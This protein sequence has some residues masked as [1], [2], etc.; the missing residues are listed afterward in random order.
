LNLSF[1]PAIAT[2]VRLVLPGVVLLA[3][4]AGGGSQAPLTQQLSSFA[5]QASAGAP[6]RSWISPD[7]TKARLL[8]ASEDEGEGDGFVNIY[9]QNG[10][11]QASIGHLG[12]LDFPIGL[13][14]D[15][16]GNLYVANSNGFNVPVYHRGASMPFKT[17]LDPNEYPDAVTIDS[18]GTVYVAS[19]TTTQHMPGNVA[20]YAGG[21]TSPTSTLTDPNWLSAGAVT[22]DSSNNLYVCFISSSGP[23]GVDEFL[24]GTTMPINLGLKLEHTC[25]GL[26][27]DQHQNLVVADPGALKVEVFPP[28]S[29]SPSITFPAGSGFPG[30]L[31]FANV[32][33]LYASGDN[34]V[35]QVEEFAYPSGKVIN[36]ITNGFQPDFCV[37][38]V[39]TDP[40]VV[41]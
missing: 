17:L 25:N 24:A 16:K 10:K 40:L 4:C 3:G 18:K 8:Y 41:K 13:A 30:N 29:T 26:A 2:V 15:K 38:G 23:Y 34:G 36:K 22:V 31:A 39:A 33:Q 9:D 11:N 27:K 28:G 5:R 14:V 20:V 6:S 12:G 1:R 7:A 32:N 19:E 21:S 35:P 37:C